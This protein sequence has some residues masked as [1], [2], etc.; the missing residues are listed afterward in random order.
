MKKSEL[1]AK[2][3]AILVQNYGKPSTGENQ[4]S[5]DPPGD[6]GR[7]LVLNKFPELKEIIVDLLTEQYE[8]FIKEIQ[9]VAPRPTTFK[10]VLSNEQYFFLTFNEKSWTAQIEGKKYWLL[11]IKEEENAAHALARIL[12]HG[13]QELPEESADVEDEPETEEPE[14][15]PE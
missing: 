11:N 14:E 10:I 13:N 4:I 5:L 6:S 15:E 8:L 9:W 1:K 3:K 2:I 12:R 7:F